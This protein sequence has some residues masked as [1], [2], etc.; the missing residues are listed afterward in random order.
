MP[1]ARFRQSVPLLLPLAALAAGIVAGTFVSLPVAITFPA[2]AAVALALMRKR[3][4]SLLTTITTAGVLLAYFTLPPKL[5]AQLEETEATF[6]GIIIEH[7]DKDR[8]VATI[9]QVDSVADKAGTMSPVG[10]FRA[11]VYF[12]DSFLWLSPGKRV[13]FTCRLSSPAYDPQLPDDPD[14]SAYYRY[15]GISATGVVFSGDVSAAV[16]DSRWHTT[17]HS[18]RQRISDH[19]YNS[20]LSTEC[21]AFLDALLLGDDTHLDPEFRKGLTLAGLSHIIALSG[22]H[23][24]IIA[25]LIA[26]LL[27]PLYLLGYRKAALILSITALGLYALLTGLSASVVRSVI[28]ASAVMIAVLSDRAVNS[29]NA[30]C[31][32]AIAI[33]CFRP[34]DLFSPGMQMSFM[35]VASILLL[36]NALN[37]VYQRRR[38]LYTSA[39]VITTIIAAVAGTWIIACHYFHYT[40]LWFLPVNLPMIVLLPVEITGGALLVIS[41]AFGISI[42]CLPAIIEKVYRLIAWIGDTVA[43]APVT[44]MSDIYLNPWCIPVYFIGLYAM[45]E[46]LRERAWHLCA[47]AAGLFIATWGVAVLPYGSDTTAPRLYI[48]HDNAWTDV[49]L[50][51]ADDMLI[52]TSA[53]R[54]SPAETAERFTSSHVDF[55]SRRHIHCPAVS[56]HTD[57]HHRRQRQLLK[58]GGTTLAIA[59]TPTDT[60]MFAPLTRTRYTLVTRNSQYMHADQLQRHYSPDTVILT[61]EIYPSHHDR[62]AAELDSISQPFI[63]L[64]DHKGVFSRDLK[65]LE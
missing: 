1:P 45:A 31:F 2:T 30:L 28:M 58:T 63:S 21:A 14:L 49:V 11:G 43:T 15:K 34:H 32:A 17:L 57:P 38:L 42:P 8:T 60:S 4:A 59:G 55:I 40:S 36:A 64:R 25:L 53:W 7:A 3:Y 16:G 51:N 56:S 37:P 62:L 26:V 52:A 65:W 23:V 13:R 50:H 61:R 29:L 24:A 19:L 41:G 27:L 20:G 47:L 22:T 54:E 35:A 46:A 18:I 39:G 33:L 5:P 48:T 12:F 10:S 9:I 44:G 6:S